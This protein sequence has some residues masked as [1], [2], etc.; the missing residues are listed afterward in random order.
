MTTKHM[1]ALLV[2]AAEAR[3]MLLQGCQCAQGLGDAAK[4]SLGDGRIQ[5]GIAVIC[6]DG[7]AV[8][9]WRA[10]TS[11]N[12]CSRSSERIRSDSAASSRRPFWR[13]WNPCVST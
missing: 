10:S 12:F 13:P 5:Q 3:M 9:D 2:E 11:G 6:R 8:P 1:A 7:Q 4:I